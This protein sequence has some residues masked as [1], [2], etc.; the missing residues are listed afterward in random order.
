MRGPQNYFAPDAADPAYLD[1]TQFLHFRDTAQSIGEFLVKFDLLPWKSGRTY[2][3][4]GC[5]S[6]RPCG[7]VAP[8]A[9]KLGSRRRPRQFGDVRDCA[10]YSSFFRPAC[11]YSGERCFSGWWWRWGVSFVSDLGARKSRLA[12]RRAKIEGGPSPKT[13]ESNRCL[14]RKPVYLSA[15]R[16]VAMLE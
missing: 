13:G 12:F 6:G 3:A 15:V 9:R 2:A 7:P 5:V 8:T 4:W 16:N 14:L 1:V 10:E 11:R